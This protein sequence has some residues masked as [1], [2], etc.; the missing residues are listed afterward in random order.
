MDW[1]KILEGPRGRQLCVLV[2]MSVE[3][4]QG[5]ATSMETVGPLTDAY[6]CTEV[7]QPGVS[8]FGGGGGALVAS[9]AADIVAALKNL[10]VTTPRE[11]Q[12]PEVFEE[13][14]GSAR[15][16]QKPDRRD[17]LFAQPEV[18]E[19]L[20]PWAET[21]GML[22]EAAWWPNMV[23]VEHQFLV[24][25]ERAGSLSVKTPEWD[26]WRHHAGNAEYQARRLHLLDPHRSA[27]G[28]WWSTPMTDGTTPPWPNGPLTGKP[29]AVT[30]LEDQYYSEEDAVWAQVI[31]PANPR[32]YEITGVQDWT[33]LC[34]ANP[35]DV[36]ASRRHDWYACTGRAGD[37]VIP[38]WSEVAKQWDGIHLPLSAYLEL[39]GRALPVDDQRATVIAGWSPG[40]TYWLSPLVG[41]RK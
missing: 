41:L 31:A 40:M 35:L 7:G 9:A 24:A 8:F 33:D 25:P 10:A 16:W 6:F 37:W 26:S 38:D 18:V 5:P 39:V 11:P 1:T 28:A 36:S 2:A 34:R 3:R 23:N 12:L 19:L 29:L 32:I 17:F 14:V 21:L 15:Y 30:L 4:E 20:K 22:P 27:T 13:V